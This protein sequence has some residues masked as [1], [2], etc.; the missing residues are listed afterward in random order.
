[1]LSHVL[2]ADS[3]TDPVV[4]AV[5]LSN[6]GVPKTPQP[7]ATITRSGVQGD[8]QAHEKHVKPTRAISLFDEELLH[9]LQALGFV[10]RPGSIGENVTLRNVFVQ[11]MAPGTILEIGSVRVRL[12]EPRRPCFVLDAIDVRLKE[13]IV[14]RCGYMASVAAGGEIRPGMSVRPVGGANLN[15]PLVQ[16]GVN[17]MRAAEVIA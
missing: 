17:E 5:C 10:L 2:P 13:A 11:Q 7:V 1:M 6:G 3:N 15:L 4:V 8:R 12:E 16:N 9:D 14:G